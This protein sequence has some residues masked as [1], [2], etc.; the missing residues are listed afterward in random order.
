[1]PRH[2][3]ADP[4]TPLLQS[5]V[6]RASRV[7][8]PVC[9][10]YPTASLSPQRPRSEKDITRVS[11]TLSPSSIL[12]GGTFPAPGVIHSHRPDRNAH[13]LESRHSGAGPR[14]LRGSTPENTNELR[15]F[16]GISPQR[17]A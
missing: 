8:G 6:I 14:V 1:M 3:A 16:Y 7:D 15:T 12:G 10:W 4:R 11:G 9:A 2:S 17:I 5:A 13:R